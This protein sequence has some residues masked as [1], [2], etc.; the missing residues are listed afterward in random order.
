MPLR[1]NS[2]P[3]AKIF[4]WQPPALEGLTHSL[5]NPYRRGSDGQA[6][7][8]AQTTEGSRVSRIGE[9]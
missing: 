2:I 6:I 5:S 8:T 9:P 7:T 4:F 3:A 1:W